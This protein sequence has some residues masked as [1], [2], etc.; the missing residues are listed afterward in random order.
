MILPSTKT[1]STATSAPTT[2]PPTISTK[3]PQSTT[4]TTAKQ[5]LPTTKTTTKTPTTTT[6]TTTKQPTPASTTTKQPQPPPTTTTIK[7]PT[8]TTKTTAK[9]PTTTTKTT[10][11][12][13]TTTTTKTAQQPSTTTTKSTRITIY[14]MP[15][16]C[17]TGAFTNLTTTEIVEQLVKNLTVDKADLSSERRKLTSAKD[18]RNSS[19]T[20]GTVGV[21][22]IS[23]TVGSIFLLDAV[24]VVSFILRH[25]KRNNRRRMKRNA[26]QNE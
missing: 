25:C 18:E 2:P 13:P 6:T 21:V 17:S 7:Q 23:V 24:R 8:T 15:C 1:T 4:E 20:I 26:V 3:E 16:L 11:K 22:I 14:I 9:Q 19:Q 12:Q 10:T 5:P